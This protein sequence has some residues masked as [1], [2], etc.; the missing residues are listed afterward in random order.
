MR[1]FHAAPRSS[2]CGYFAASGASEPVIRAARSLNPRLLV[3][4]RTTY[5]SEVAATRNAGASAVV[6][7]EGE[8]AAAMVE[9]VLERLGATAD[10]LDRARARVRE[11]LTPR[12]S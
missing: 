11:A 6:S 7:A 5:V 3:L 12:H 2:W 10:Q 4:A 9:R 1:S 8:V